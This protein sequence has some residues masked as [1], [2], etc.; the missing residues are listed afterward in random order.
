VRAPRDIPVA[1]TA[2]AVAWLLCLTAPAGEREEPNAVIRSLYGRRME[3][4][5]RTGST[6]D[7][8]ALGKDL[9]AAAREAGAAPDLQAALCVKACELARRHP[10]GWATAAAAMEFLAESSPRRRAEAMGVLADLHRAAYARGSPAQRREAGE[11]LIELLGS[12]AEARR[13]ERRYAEAARLAREAYS[14]AIVLNSPAREAASALLK[15]CDFL[16]AAAA[17][18]DA[19]RRHMQADPNSAA[20]SRNDLVI[21]LVAELDD[22]N[23]AAALLTA[24]V[25][26]A[27]RTYVPMAATNPSGLAPA[28]LPELGAWYR[29]LAEKAPEWAKVACLRRARGYYELFLSGKAAATDEPARLKVSLALEELNRDLA[30]RGA[31]PLLGRLL[32]SAAAVLAFERDDYFRRGTGVFLRDLSGKG[33]HAGVHGV[34]LAPGRAG[35]AGLFEAGA[36]LDL[37]SSSSLQI[38]GDQTIAMWLCPTALGAR[39]NPYNKA[40]GGEG[41]WTLEPPGLIN[42][43]HGTAGGNASP[44]N[45][46]GTGKN[47]P[48]GHWTH[49][50]LVRDL[51]HRKLRWYLNGV[52]AAEAAAPYAKAGASSAHLLIGK[53]YA[54][55]Y[56]GGIDEFVLLAEA[57][58]DRDVAALYRAGRAGRSLGH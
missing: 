46:F 25:D 33:N 27:A 32:K 56:V 18:A 16:A 52:R 24:D 11:K 1:V 28:V 55:Q 14:V 8:A 36:F 44:Y 26:E 30:Q 12:L 39:R 35:Q 53:G 3:E 50:V 57:L 49:V 2:A 20:K 37:G 15:Q 9:L 5:Q 6:A 45:S 54:G 48:A 4:V 22:A 13:G 17:R 29:S 10:D 58:S 23:A 47:L 31:D 40:Y 42:Y 7:D 34:K 21:L 38:T 41:T 43:Y 51:K 19:L